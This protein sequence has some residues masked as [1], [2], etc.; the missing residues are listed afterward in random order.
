[1][2]ADLVAEGAGSVPD[3]D[4][5]LKSVTEATADDLVVRRC[6]RRF[7]HAHGDHC[8]EMKRWWDVVAQPLW[9][10]VRAGSDA[11]S[12]ILRRPR[13]R[14]RSTCLALQI[15]LM[16]Y[17]TWFWNSRLRCAGSDAA[18]SLSALAGRGAMPN[19][20]PA[21]GCGPALDR[22]GANAG[23]SVPNMIHAKATYKRFTDDY[24]LQFGNKSSQS[25]IRE[26]LVSLTS[27]NQTPCLGGAL[28]SGE[29]RMILMH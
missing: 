2:M 29:A 5:R 23:V 14:W 21:D 1:M 13:G 3:T 8:L 12:K 4:V 16:N 18:L 27:E 20:K 24:D 26:D 28:R 19:E 17:G 15:V 10:G 7:T 11:P 22:M 6:R 9:P 25:V